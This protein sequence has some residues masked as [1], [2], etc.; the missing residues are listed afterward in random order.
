[1]KLAQ[2]LPLR[3]DPAN[4]QLLRPRPKDRTDSRPSCYRWVD[5]RHPASGLERPTVSVSNGWSWRSAS[6]WLASMAGRSAS[7]AVAL[8]WAAPRCRAAAAPT[9]RVAGHWTAAQRHR[10]CRSGRTAHPAGCV[11]SRRIRG[12]L[13]LDLL[14]CTGSRTNAPRSLTALNWHHLSQ[15][16]VD[17]MAHRDSTAEVF[18]C[19]HSANP[20]FEPRRVV[21]ASLYDHGSGRCVI[22]VTTAVFQL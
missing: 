8:S 10:P 9:R 11:G 22:H 20:M 1:M 21:A 7:S 18:G 15:V 6:H 5:S 19:W 2:C 3:R 13:G 4:S 17:T 14:V 12:A 16:E